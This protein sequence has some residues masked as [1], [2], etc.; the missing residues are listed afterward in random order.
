MNR[1]DHE[2]WI[3][4]I[5]STIGSFGG[6]SG[7]MGANQ[8]GYQG[9]SSG[10]GPTFNTASLGNGYGNMQN[11]GAGNAQNMYGS[12]GAQSYT[13]FNPMQQNLYNAY[14]QYQMG[15]TQN[16]ISNAT[17]STAG[18]GRQASGVTGGNP[19]VPSAQSSQSMPQT[20]YIPYNGQMVP[21]NYTDGRWT[22]GDAP[23]L[24]PDTK[25]QFDPNN[26]YQSNP[27]QLT[28]QMMADNP[29]A[30]Q[31]G[32]YGD[33]MYFTP[34]KASSQP[35]QQAP[36]QPA[37]QSAPA[38]TPPPPNPYAQPQQSYGRNPWGGGVTPPWSFFASLFGY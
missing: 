18:G 12:Y 10:Q 35:A 9:Q 36:Q 16:A 13:P 38:Y 26:A 34:Y 28:Q 14:D 29:Y 2:V 27:G 25:V 15:A 32:Y 22:Q 31:G 37:Q 6:G 17:P 24:A 23:F 11:Y 4:D 30:T 3:C 33:S 20:Q 5:Q 7:N 1:F 8:S 19:T 21:F